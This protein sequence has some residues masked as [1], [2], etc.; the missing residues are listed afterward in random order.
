MLQVFSDALH[1]LHLELEPVKS[2]L[3]C[4]TGV[5]GALHL[6]HLELEPVKSVLY[7]VTGVS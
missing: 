4:V 3:Y 1:L 5:S 2:V 7:C 6:L